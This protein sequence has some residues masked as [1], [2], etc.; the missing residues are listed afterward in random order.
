[1]AAEVYVPSKNLLKIAQQVKV[2][3]TRKKIRKRR[4]IRISIEVKTE[5]L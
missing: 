4:C 1:M 2:I 3:Y 5:E